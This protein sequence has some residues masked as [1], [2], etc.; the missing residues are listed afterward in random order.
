MKKKEAKIGTGWGWQ[1]ARKVETWDISFHLEWPPLSSLPW[2]NLYECRQ[3]Q[4]HWESNFRWGQGKSSLLPIVHTSIAS[5]R[6]TI[7]GKWVKSSWST[8][9]AF[10]TRNKLLHCNI[11]HLLTT[12]TLCPSLQQKLLCINTFSIERTHQ[13]LMKA[14]CY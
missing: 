10:R 6:F 7:I 3:R 9:K 11:Y 8:Q 4:R 1:S 2:V 14:P 12:W 13:P 5:S